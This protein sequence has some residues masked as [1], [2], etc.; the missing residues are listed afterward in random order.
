[1][2]D[3]LAKIGAKRLANMNIAGR[4]SAFLE[5]LDPDH[6]Y[7]SP[8]AIFYRPDLPQAIKRVGKPY[9]ITGD[10]H[11]IFPGQTN[12]QGFTSNPHV[13][14][15]RVQNARSHRRRDNDGHIHRDDALC[16]ASQP[17]RAAQV[18]F[19]SIENRHMRKFCFAR[20]FAFLLS[21]AKDNRL[22]VLPHEVGHFDLDHIA[23][24]L[25][26]QVPAIGIFAMGKIV[27]AGQWLKAGPRRYKP[28]RGIAVDKA[29]AAQCLDAHRAITG[30]RCCKFINRA[31][32]EPPVQPVAGLPVCTIRPKL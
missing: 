23:I 17:S 5:L 19:I 22:A 24:G 30:N 32:A 27:Q 14:Q 7:L 15:P 29:I 26:A 25:A 31:S 12:C 28:R 3:G 1:M 2:K 8:G 4:G 6:G 21:F 16:P 20:Q 9:L 18:R 13:A 10:K 11:E